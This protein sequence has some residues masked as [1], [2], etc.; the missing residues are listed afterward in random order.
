VGSLIDS[1]IFIAAERGA[2]APDEARRL[3]TPG[4]GFAMASV[5]AAELLHG[6]HRADTPE[7]RKR[8]EEIVEAFLSVVPIIDFDL[9][10]ARVRARVDAEL[11][12]KGITVPRDD[13]SI[14][15]IALSRGF[16]VITRNER[17][18][19]RVPGL[20]VVIW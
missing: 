15:S 19:R 2:L 11:Q 8:R 18:F 5:T 3:I 20:V 1:S 13:L 14:A 6:V 16:D 9:A 12:A 7:R 17:D 4:A 10:A